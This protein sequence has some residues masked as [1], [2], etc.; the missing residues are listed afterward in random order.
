MQYGGLIIWVTRKFMLS[1]WTPTRFQSI[2]HS[3]IG[4]KF[5]I[6]R[7]YANAKDS[8]ICPS[9]HSKYYL[10]GC[11]AQTDARSGTG[12][13]NLTQRHCSPYNNSQQS[14]HPASVLPHAI[15][16]GLETAAPAMTETQ[17]GE[18][19]RRPRPPGVRHARRLIT[20]ARLVCGDGGV[21]DG[22]K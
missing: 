18:R 8:T 4:H 21:G 7:S 22:G 12:R 5:R 10:E 2:N 11:L 20:V 17:R 3:A 6:S 9:I 19:R 1:E 14:L 15:G 16:Q 13:S